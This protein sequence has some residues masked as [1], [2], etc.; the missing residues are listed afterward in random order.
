MA[1][2]DRGDA[3]EAILLAAAEGLRTNDEGSDQERESM[4]VKLKRINVVVL[5]VSDL[6]RSKTFYRDTLGFEV[7]FEDEAGVY[8]ELEGAALMLLTHDGARDLLTT[9]AVASP[10]PAGTTSQL[11]AF[12]EDVDQVH[13]ELVDQGVEFV[14]EPV[15]REW[16]MRT[17]HFKDPEGNIWE[18][19]QQLSQ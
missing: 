16:G 17:A 1:R 14:R 15:D 3:L 4:G 6:D 7:T 19:A 5:F 13:R 9:E 2:P 10:R 8:F 18:L 11:V 12:V